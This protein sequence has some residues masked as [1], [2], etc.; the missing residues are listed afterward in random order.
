M[1]WISCKD[2]T[3][4]DG[5]LVLVYT[6]RKVILARRF[7]NYWHLDYQSN[8]IALAKTDKWTE[9]VMP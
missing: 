8:P 9:I 6:M 2:A 7:K 4:K 3:P 1:I 5:A